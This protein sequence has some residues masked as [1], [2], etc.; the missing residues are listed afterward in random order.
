MT[1]LKHFHV[2]G[3]IL[4]MTKSLHWILK[5]YKNYKAITQIKC[6]LKKRIFPNTQYNW[7]YAE[8]ETTKAK[9]NHRMYGDI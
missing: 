3:E 1:H 5:H 4:N 2:P 8:R 7:K 9:L 6:E